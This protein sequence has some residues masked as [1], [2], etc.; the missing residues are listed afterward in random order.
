MGPPYA[1]PNKDDI[2]EL[3]K[4]GACV[5]TVKNMEPPEI[6]ILTED[7][8]LNQRTKSLIWGWPNEELGDRMGAEQ[9]F[10]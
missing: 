8:I 5:L 6:G 7:R 10:R 3:W 1:L 9:C 4:C 2:Y